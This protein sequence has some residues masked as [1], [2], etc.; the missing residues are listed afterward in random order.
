[1]GFRHLATLHLSARPLILYGDCEHREAVQHDGGI[2]SS[3]DI[4]GFPLVYVCTSRMCSRT[5][6][7]A[8]LDINTLA[9]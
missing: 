9:R 6:V 4:W 1:M 7:S 3:G 8:Y 5:Y 2:E